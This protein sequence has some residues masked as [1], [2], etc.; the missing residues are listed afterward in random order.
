MNLLNLQTLQWDKEIVEF[1]A[2]RLLH[3]LPPAVPSA[4]IAGQLHPYFA[5]YGLPPAIPV[6]TWFGDNPCSLS[7][8]GA[9]T[10]TAVISFGTSDTFFSVMDKFRV[11]PHGYGHLF[12]SGG[13]FTRPQYYSRL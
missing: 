9:T 5:T 8:S 11:D 3:K 4:T 1:T 7:G 2:P 13:C 10:G 6:V 12:G